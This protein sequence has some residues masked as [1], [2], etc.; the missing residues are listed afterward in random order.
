MTAKRLGRAAAL[1][2]A[3]TAPACTVSPLMIVAP[4]DA[5]STAAAADAGDAQA[6]PGFTLPPAPPSPDAGGSPVGP[7]VTITVPPIGEFKE[8]NVG[9]YKLGPP[10]QHDGPTLVVAEDGRCAATVAVVRDFKGRNEPGGHP[11]FEHFGGAGISF[12]L[13]E[14]VLGPDRKPVYASRCEAMPDPTA[15]PFGQQT[16]S[17]AAFDQWYRFADGVNRPYILFLAFESKAGISTFASSDFFPV[18]G[19]GWAEGS[20]GQS[21]NYGFTTEVHTSFRYGGGERFTFSGDDDLWVFVNGKLAL[22]LGG[23]HNEEDGTIDFDLLAPVLGI[24]VGNVYP[25]D[26]FHAER[27]TLAS[28]FRIDTNV[29]FVDCGRIID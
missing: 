25:M 23:L 20:A 11:D 16:T 3:V 15:C 21:H 5:G 1:L 26:L 27:H 4:P 29:S 6:P 28:D 19:A 14:R 22:D 13:L 10:I 24:T 12:G 9:G 8:A 17:Q 18:D 7:A 2:L